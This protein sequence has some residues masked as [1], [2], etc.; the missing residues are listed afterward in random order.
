[1]AP[2]VIAGN[3]YYA[4]PTGFHS[5][6]R[7]YT[8]SMA[9]ISSSVLLLSQFTAGSALV[10]VTGNAAFQSIPL[11][12]GVGLSVPLSVGLNTIVVTHSLDG[13]YT[14]TLTRAVPDVTMIRVDGQLVDLT[15]RNGLAISPSFQGGSFVYSGVVAT[16]VKK[17]SFLP[18]FST[19]NT[20][21]FT[22]SLS[23][24]NVP[25]TLVNGNE[26]PSAD[27]ATW[28]LDIYFHLCT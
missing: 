3:A 1:M 8:G 4:Q 13:I 2:S 18:S 23:G 15:A 27:A 10:S 22:H 7:F 6:L 20:L 24:G 28:S 16:I 17:I 14:Y 21:A 26:T 19:S 11:L 5:N 12:P 25:S 9:F